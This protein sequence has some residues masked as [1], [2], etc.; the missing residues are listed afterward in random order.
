[1]TVHGRATIEGSG[2]DLPS[3]LQQICRDLYGEWWD[4]FASTGL[5][6]RIEADRVLTFHLDPEDAAAAAAEAGLPAPDEG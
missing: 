1:M 3:D 6:G 2:K 5:Y 4:D